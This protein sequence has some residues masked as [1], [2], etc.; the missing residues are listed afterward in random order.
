MSRRGIISKQHE[1]RLPRRTRSQHYLEEF[2]EKHPGV[3]PHQMVSTR[4]TL[5][6]LTF[7]RRLLDPNS[8]YRDVRVESRWTQ[9]LLDMTEIPLFHVELYNQELADAE[10]ILKTLY[11]P[12]QIL[13]PSSP[14]DMP[15]DENGNVMTGDYT[16]DEWELQE[17]AYAGYNGYRIYPFN[18]P[19]D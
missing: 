4:S 9:Y 6:W 7:P 15:V 1:K 13:Q 8:Y 10:Y 16:A 5:G 19:P 18:S 14:A 11:M 12:G 17:R 2:K 3:D